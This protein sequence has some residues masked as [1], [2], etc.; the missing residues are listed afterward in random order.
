M[1]R[2]PDLPRG[3]RTRSLWSLPPTNTPLAQYQDD[4]IIKGTNLATPYRINLYATVGSDLT[5]SVQ[6]AVEDFL[7][8]FLEGATMRL[9]NNLI[10]ANL[11]PS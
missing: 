8:D 6:F 3:N 5:G 4:L 7:A 10:H 11:G 9:Q 1:I 2:L